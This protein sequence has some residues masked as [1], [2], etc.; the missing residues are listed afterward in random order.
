MPNMFSAKSYATCAAAECYRLHA[1]LRL[2]S[3][4]CACPLQGQSGQRFAISRFGMVGRHPDRGLAR[5]NY[6]C[7]KVAG[8]KHRQKRHEQNACD[9][10]IAAGSGMRRRDGGACRRR[11]PGGL[12][13]ADGEDRGPSRRVMLKLGAMGP[14]VDN[15]QNGAQ[16][17]ATTRSSPPGKRTRRNSIC[18]RV[19]GGKGRPGGLSGAAGRYAW[20]PTTAVSRSTRAFSS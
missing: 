12:G 4:V 10:C 15:T 8:Q 13:Q 1:T 16:A 11:R 7:C 19:G 18:P 14:L 20:P 3:N 2:Y 9:G 17:A 6:N 5:H